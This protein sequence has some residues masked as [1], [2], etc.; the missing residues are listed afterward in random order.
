MSPPACLLVRPFVSPCHCLKE[1]LHFHAPIGAHFNRRLDT[2]TADLRPIISD[3]SLEFSYL[4]L[5]F[6]AAV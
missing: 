6:N 3:R 2:I 1:K 4:D 5:I